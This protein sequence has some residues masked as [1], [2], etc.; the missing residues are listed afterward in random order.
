MLERLELANVGPAPAMSLDLAPRFNLFTGDNGLGKSF[1]LD[2]AWWA[3][4]RRWPQEVNPRMT[5]GLPAQPRDPAAPA[6]ILL[7]VR[8]ATTDVE[9]EA[10]YSSA[11][12]AWK[13]NRGR[14][15]AP[16]LVV[17]AHADGSFSVWDPVRNYW[18]RRTGAAERRPAYVFT[19][20]EVWD[21]L[22]NQSASRP[23]P[24]CNGLL[25]D[26][27]HWINARD[28]RAEA[29]AT[30]LRAL[31]P[32]AADTFVPGPLVRL[33][34]QD[35]REIPSIVTRGHAGPVPVLHASAGVRRAVALAYMLTWTRSEH[36]LAVQR[37]SHAPARR[38]IIL[39]DEVESHLHP[40]WQRSMLKSL[41]EAGGAIF[42]GMDFQY[43]VSTHSPLVLASAEPWFDAAQDAWFDIDLAGDPPR[44]TLQRRP[45]VPLGT[46]G[47]WLT[48]EAFDLATDRGSVEAEEAVLR[49]RA[50]L[51]ERAPRLDAVMEVHDGLRRT[52][53]E[54]DPFWVRWNAFVERCGGEP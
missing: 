35:A 24:V 9:Y 49:A 44:V 51:R 8:S 36:R 27:A 14:P 54:L 53:P 30:V 2:V 29:M 38:T 26:W 37:T 3:L 39:F 45:Y 12:G 25:Y 5:S 42:A 10:T 48:S 17:Y 31:A 22:W 4:T 16:G 23:V 21:G 33:S 1:L 40:R 41:Q 6:K 46:A 7:R 47:H 19:E 13:G 52:L 32:T 11:D 50:V 15:W 20:A 18:N 34:L 28:D 43:L